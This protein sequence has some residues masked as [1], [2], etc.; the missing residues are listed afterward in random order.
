MRHLTLR[1]SQRGIGLIDGLVAL[2][3]LAFGLLAM[4]RFQSRLVAQSTESQ[5]RVAA[6]QFGDELLSTALVDVGNAACYTLPQQGAC[7]SAPAQARADDWSLR[8]LA[9]LPGSPTAGVALDTANNRLTVT[10]T[11]TGRH[12]S[13]TR[14]M[15]MATD[16]TP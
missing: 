11:W 4:T 9:A 7:N 14:T 12:A 8:T 1:R 3:V 5:Q 2:A 10:I 16:V 6:M 15:Q 13:E